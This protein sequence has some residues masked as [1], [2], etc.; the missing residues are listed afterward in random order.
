MCF[1]FFLN[2]GPQ[3]KH[4]QKLSI[5][6]STEKNAVS[7]AGPVHITIRRLPSSPAPLGR[8]C[9]DNSASNISQFSQ[10]IEIPQVAEI[11]NLKNEEIIKKCNL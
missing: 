1:N 3:T 6:G 9:L 5:R 10:K 11:S 2:W 8:N 7:A 4:P